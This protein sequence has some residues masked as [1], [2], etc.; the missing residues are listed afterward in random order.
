METTDG[1][2]DL[3]AG[4]IT[5][6][7]TQAEP[8]GAEGNERIRYPWIEESIKL[9]ESDPQ[10]ESL[11]KRWR[12][13]I[14][15]QFPQTENL[16]ALEGY[17]NSRYGRLVA[18]IYAVIESK[19]AELS[20]RTFSKS[21]E[22]K[23]CQSLR[24]GDVSV[25]SRAVV[26]E[27]SCFECSKRKVEEEHVPYELWK[28]LPSKAITEALGS[29]YHLHPSIF[30]NMM[31]MKERSFWTSPSCNGRSTKVNSSYNPLSQHPQMAR[32]NSTHICISIEEISFT[33]ESVEPKCNLWL[34]S[35]DVNNTIVIFWMPAG[36][37][38]PMPRRV[39]RDATTLTTQT[40]TNIDRSP[41]TELPFE[42]TT[43][44]LVS[45][46]ERVLTEIKGFS[47]SQIQAANKTPIDFVLPF[48]DS[49]ELPFLS[50]I[51]EL[52][53]SHKLWYDQQKRS[54][55]R[56]HTQAAKFDSLMSLAWKKS[57]FSIENFQETVD[58]LEDVHNGLYSRFKQHAKQSKVLAITI[59]RQTRA[60]HKGRI[61]EQHV[62]EELQ[63][64]SAG[65]SLQESRKSIDQANSVG[66]ISFLAFIFLPLSLVMSFYGMNIS[67]ITGSG[68]S[69]KAFLGSLIALCVLVVLVC[70]IMWKPESWL[71]YTNF[72][73]I[74][75]Q[76]FARLERFLTEIWEILIII[77]V[78]WF[79]DPVIKL[80]KR[81]N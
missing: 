60:L 50:R 44:L 41:G 27:L 5:G 17:V 54:Y 25:D 8:T 11:V 61:L 1:S 48:L 56:P 80:V 29:T 58:Q 47:Q 64:N 3:E 55:G 39:P 70:A 28:A 24:T 57:R 53:E 74:C 2:V 71:L 6:N 65:L 4:R 19:Q 18:P 73:R 26:I 14:N 9:L 37:K 49:F 20:I 75:V 32:L 52:R 36:A 79:V 43:Y 78:S 31:H 67:D 40:Y 21:E 13:D 34:T 23:F 45:I 12:S 66:R 76:F 42:T 35:D 81:L 77:L 30:Q 16:E 68:A 72:L 51:M 62:R 10:Y 15:G 46:L 33:G 69:W 38:C 59:A 63:V 7:G 22:S